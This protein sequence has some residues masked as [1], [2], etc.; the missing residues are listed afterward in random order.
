MPRKPA[1]PPTCFVPSC[2]DDFVGQG[3]PLLIA[4]EPAEN[5]LEGGPSFLQRTAA[6]MFAAR[7]RRMVAVPKINAGKVPGKNTAVSR[8]VR[9]PRGHRSMQLDSTVFP[10]HQVTAGSCEAG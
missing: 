6:A 7:N 3:D 2:A 5:G 4:N 9:R 1:V 8:K 10:A